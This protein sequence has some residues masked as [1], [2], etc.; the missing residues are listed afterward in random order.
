MADTGGD[1]WNT[2]F[3]RVC[4]GAVCTNY[5]IVGSTGFIN[6]S[7]IIGQT[8]TVTYFPNGGVFQNQNSYQVLANNG[9]SIFSS[10]SP[11]VAAPAF[12]FVIDGLCNVPPA[13]PSDC[14]G[15]VEVCT[16][17]TITGLPNNTGNTVDLN[18]S[19]RGCLSSNEVRGQWFRFTAYQ[20][21]TLAFTIVP[22]VP[23]DYDWAIWGPYTGA[24]P[25]PPAA[26]PIRCSY[27]A[28]GGPTGM[29]LTSVDLSE[30]AGGDR[31][32]R[33]IDALA[34]Q[35]F[36]LYID[37]FSSIQTPFTLDWN[38]GGGAD[39]NC[40]VLPVQMLSFDAKPNQRMVDVTWA[41]ATERNSDHFVVERSGDGDNFVEI[42]KVDGMGNTQTT[43]NY[44]F[45]DELPHS[46]MNYYRL[47][48]VDQNG[49]AVYSETRSVFFRRT[50]LP[51]ELYPN[52]ARESIA[53]AF[54]A[55]QEGL[56]QWRMLDM[57]GRLVLQG[58][59]QM[60]IGTNRIEIALERVEN[61]SYMVE[62]LDAN[63]VPMGNSRFVK[64]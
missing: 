35:T 23:A 50:G 27:A 62:L 15:S 16:D 34:G 46:G 5:S 4:V 57:S 13:P 52:P 36:L 25:C 19:N 1:G 7:G 64:H 20:P 63:A 42:G 58:N 18:A 26:P 9:F 44:A 49:D 31:F 10:A 59:A 30:G 11:P 55:E 40:L 28:G 33:Y 17:Q 60:Q 56:A 47:K 48:Q 6:F 37:R 51:I 61:G 41:T 8:V 3:V 43:T 14:A 54:D 22:G 24:P 29:N 12:L 53:L 38:L 45:V 32:V 39:I 2:S 21:G